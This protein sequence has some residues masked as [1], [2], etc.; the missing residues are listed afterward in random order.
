[1]CDREPDTLSTTGGVETL[2]GEPSYLVANTIA[3]RPR[4]HVVQL[5]LVPGPSCQTAVDL[6]SWNT[7]QDTGPVC[8][9]VEDQGVR[10]DSIS[11]P[12]LR[13]TNA[14]GRPSGRPFAF[15][16][17]VIHPAPVAVRET[18]ER[19]IRTPTGGSTD[20][21]GA[22][23]DRRTSGPGARKRGRAGCMDAPSNPNEAAIPQA[24]HGVAVEPRHAWL[25]SAGHRAATHGVA[26]PGARTPPH[27]TNLRSAKLPTSRNGS[28]P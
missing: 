21:P 27:P 16:T 15:L 18:M 23:P 1:M 6:Q 19:G 7:T 25:P 17:F 4:S 10:A 9:P 26:L 28:P 11:S 22:N 24:T 8:V 12:S 13:Q 14:K 2:I 20:S 5:C 3:S